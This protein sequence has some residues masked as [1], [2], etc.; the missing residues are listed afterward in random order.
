MSLK[1]F[2]RFLAWAA[3]LLIVFFTLAPIQFRPESGLPVQWERLLAFVVLGFLLTVAYPRHVVLV[4]VVVLGAAL[5]LE[6]LQLVTPSRHGRVFDLAVKLAG[7]SAGIVA[8]W[9]IER[10]PAHRQMARVNKGKIS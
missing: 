4:A 10:W 9:V 7:G 6:L 2:L 3:L 8:A 5:L 1:T